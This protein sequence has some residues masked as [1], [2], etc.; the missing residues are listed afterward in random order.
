[1]WP[2]KRRPATNASLISV[3]DYPRAIDGRPGYT[4][5]WEI[6]VASEAPFSWGA[7]IYRYQ[8]HELVSA[9]EAIADTYEQARRDSQS[10]V[11]DQMP[12]FRVL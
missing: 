4:A 10:W 5:Y 3:Q 12:Q 2:F 7:K 9:H 1:M 11:L 8:P 6:G